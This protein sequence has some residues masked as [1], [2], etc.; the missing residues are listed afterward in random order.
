MLDNVTSVA[1]IN[2]CGGT[3]SISLNQIALDIFKW[4]EE[5][6]LTVHA[7]HVP[8]KDNCLA[9]Y[10]SRFRTDASDW[11][12]DP[13]VFVR[14]REMWPTNVDLFASS[15]NRQLESFASWK[16]QLESLAIDGFSLNWGHFTG[17]LFPSFGLIARC[18]SKRIKR[19]LRW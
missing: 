15:W 11:R 14:L 9:D 18:L 12:L 8:G 1:F 7:F 5:R 13:T 16:H 3:N 17:Y 2:K 10:Y 6:Q 4:C 19:K